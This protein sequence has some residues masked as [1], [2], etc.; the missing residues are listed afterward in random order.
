MEIARQYKHDNNGRLLASRAYL[1]PRGWRSNDVIS[2]ATHELLAAGLIFQTVIGQRPNKASWFAL[3]CH[4]LNPD[5]R[6]D[7]G[8][9]RTFR[10]GAYKLLPAPKIEPNKKI[11]RPSDGAVC[12][13]I[14]PPDGVGDALS[15]PSGGAVMALFGKRSIPSGGH[16]LE[17]PSVAREVKHVRR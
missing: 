11:L 15:T 12:G 3:T 2:R 1:L 6:Y 8:V 5:A 4:Q 10:Q 17:T 9:E 7:A 14:A 13:T 16:P